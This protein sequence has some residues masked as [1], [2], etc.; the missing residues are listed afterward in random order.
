VVDISAQILPG[1]SA[2][3]HHRGGGG[4][5]GQAGDDQ[6]AIS[7]HLGRAAGP[8]RALIEE[9]LGSRAVEVAHGEVM[10]VAKQ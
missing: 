3:L 6:F 10:A 2:G 9:W 1:V 8:F 7:R 5:R 4:G